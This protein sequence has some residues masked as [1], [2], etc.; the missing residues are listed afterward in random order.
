MGMIS[1]LGV[2]VGLAAACG[3]RVFVPL[4]VLSVA[5][6]AGLVEPGAA[7]AWVGS[8]PAV[9]ALATASVLEVA[10]YYVPWVDHALDVVATPAAA[11]AGGLAL[12]VPLLGSAAHVDPMLTGAASLL[13][14]GG[15]AATVQLGTVALRAGS[16]ATTGGLGNPVVATAENTAASVLAVVAVVAPIVV[17]LVLLAAAWLAWRMW[18]GR[19][20][21]GAA[22]DD[23]QDH[24]RAATAGA[25]RLI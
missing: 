12:A 17:G 22:A 14:G 24:D 5:V 10:G 4:L 1:A 16:T 11:V 20:G 25:T 15:L 7:M 18:F 2:G 8:L 3:F 6:R 19:R 9:M 13:A 23:R 21:R